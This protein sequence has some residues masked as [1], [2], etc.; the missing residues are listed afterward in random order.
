M[1]IIQILK[2]ELAKILDE[3]D[4]S[5]QPVVTLQDAING[6]LNAI[7]KYMLT[8]VN[9]PPLGHPAGLAAATPVL[10]SMNLPGAALV[11]IPGAFQAYAGALALG[12]PLP[13][14]ALP[15]PSPFVLV[16]PPA[17]AS[18]A[19]DAIAALVATWTV[20]GTVTIP[21]AMPVPWS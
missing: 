11:A 20:T 21:P 10:A 9:V 18:V 17:S 5:F 14:T 3:S 2:N 12:V 13:A 15:P 6:W 4:P 8:I 1:A 7:S 16:L 19:I